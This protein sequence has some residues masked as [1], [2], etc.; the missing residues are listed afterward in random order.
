MSTSPRPLRIACLHGF[1]Q[2]AQRFREKTG[3]LR[4]ALER[5]IN[6]L[7]PDFDTDC[8]NATALAELVYIDA[9]FIL[10]E[11]VGET[12]ETDSQP[13]EKVVYA[14][15]ISVLTDSRQASASSTIERDITQ[16]TWWVREGRTYTGWDQSKEYLRARFAQQVT[17]HLWCPSVSSKNVFG[18]PHFHFR[19]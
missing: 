11:S 15:N 2:N 3:A 16:R 8:S 6:L 10:E 1:R 19:S 18:P 7:D 4:K 12:S 17:S 13:R 5:G 14:P 9:P